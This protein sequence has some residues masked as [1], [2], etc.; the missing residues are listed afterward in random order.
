MGAVAYPC[1]KCGAAQDR[2]FPAEDNEAIC[3]ACEH[4]VTW[5]R[6]ALKDGKLAACPVCRLK[7]LYRQKDF[8]QAV[9][10]LV[11]LVAAV[12]APM[13]YYLSLVGAT[14][15]DAVIYLFASQVAIC[16]GYRCKAHM[17]RFDLADS[18]KP[19]DLSI[20]DYYKT[21]ATAPEGSPPPSAPLPH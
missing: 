10:C 14:L 19:F 16:Y 7:V 11:I 20:H 1:P 3:R 21:I 6:Q 17:R 9:G 2:T 5:N 13:T 8:S 12:F 18:V 15:V 4:P